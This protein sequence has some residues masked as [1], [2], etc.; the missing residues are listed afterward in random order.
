MNKAGK[1]TISDEG[2]LKKYIQN[3]YITLMTRGI[4][5]ANIFIVDEDFREYFKKALLK[6]TA[7]LT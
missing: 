6:T 3:I 7:N 5:G 4:K 1:R 2:I